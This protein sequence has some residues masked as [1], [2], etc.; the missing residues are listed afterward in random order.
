MQLVLTRLQINT[1]QKIT[2][3]MKYERAAASETNHNE[4]LKDKQYHSVLI[5]TI[6]FIK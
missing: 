5:M 4:Y 1:E 3:A 2:Q 6:V